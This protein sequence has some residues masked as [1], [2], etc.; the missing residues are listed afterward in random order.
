MICSTPTRNFFEFPY[1]DAVDRKH[2]MDFIDSIPTG[3]YVS[4][5]NLGETS[6]ASFISDWQSDTATLGSGS[7]LYNK[8]KSIGF[9]KIDSFTHNVP[10]IYFFR[11]N[12]S[13][14]TPLQSVSAVDSSVTVTIPLLSRNT[15]GTI[16][17][18]LFGPSKKWSRFIGVGKV[19]NRFLQIL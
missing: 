7:S 11:K 9:T 10:F 4:I 12:T 17:S 8:L 15:S 6:N 3:D 16:E 1:G 13:S 18:P 2:A 19:L 14:F 5:T